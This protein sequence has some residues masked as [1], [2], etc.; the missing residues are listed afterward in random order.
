MTKKGGSILFLLLILTVGIV[1][2]GQNYQ[3]NQKLA[4]VEISGVAQST[5][6][7]TSNKE[8]KKESEKIESFDKNRDQKSLLDY[9]SNVPTEDG[10]KVVSFYGDFSESD[11]WLL[12]VE[13]YMK[14]QV[15]GELETHS[16]AL[17]DFDSYRLLEENSVSLLTEKN[18]TVVFFQL[19]VYG[20][21]VRD[22]SL[23]DTKDYIMQDYEAIKQVLPET[24]VVFVTPHPSSSR[25]ESFNSR[26]LV[27]TSYLETAIEA[28]EENNLPLYHLHDLYQDAIETANFTLESTLAEDG[29]T[30]NDEGNRLYSEIFTNQLSE[31]IDTTSG[32]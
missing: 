6:K 24:L 16:I 4:L 23:S 27:Y 9:L 5:N 31:L 18:P 14:E 11:S 13:N 19:P 32:K 10:K 25:K 3:K 15:K 17:P 12:S 7:E 30:L 8:E 2:F 20:D 26:T 29:K 28:V 22:I 21:Q 1:W